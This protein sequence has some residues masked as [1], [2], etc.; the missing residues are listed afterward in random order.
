ME[1][2]KSKGHQSVHI[3]ND[4]ESRMYGYLPGQSIRIHTLG[5]FSLQ[6]DQQPIP[7]TQSRQQKPLELIQAI[8]SLG[9]RN[10]STDLIGS[11]LWPDA[12]GDDAVNAFD[13]TLHRTRRLL[14]YKDA[15]T[16]QGGR[17]TINNERVWVDAWIFERLLNQI[18]R[19]LMLSRG[20]VISRRVAELLSHA[21]EL[22]QG[23]YLCRE[24]VKPWN[25]SLRERLRSKLLRHIT[26]I[27]EISEQNGHW[28]AAIQFYQKGLEIDTFAEVLYQRLM[29]CYRH[30]GHLA[31][32][33][34][35]YQRCRYNL[36]TGLCIAPSRET[37]QIR[38]SLY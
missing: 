28:T 38:A 23:A 26:D 21:L 19:A 36:S 20:K 3:D 1:L 13:V 5:R 29:I 17:C 15:I 9:G 30:T 25:L 34:S 22:Y 7:S 10:V 14:G 35:V 12:E 16:T 24:P 11:S 37:E 32:A 6:I 27:G 8:I 2:R 18:D 31:E 33:L 4:F